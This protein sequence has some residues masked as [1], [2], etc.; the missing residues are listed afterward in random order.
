MLVP[1]YPIPAGSG[2]IAPERPVPPGAQDDDDKWGAPLTYG[3]APTTQPDKPE[4][5]KKEQ[6]ATDS[7]KKDSEK[8]RRMALGG[9]A[10]IK[11]LKKVARQKRDVDH[12]DEDL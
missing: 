11:K 3:A 7:T 1:P 6:K 12:D 9:L 2:S 8:P 4:A 5:T 10:M